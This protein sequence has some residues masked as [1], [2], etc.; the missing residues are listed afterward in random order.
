MILYHSLDYTQ[1]NKRFTY[2]PKLIE[3]V[4]DLPLL[5]W[6]HWHYDLLSETL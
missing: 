3:I 5:E 6:L 1:I 4:D 2:L